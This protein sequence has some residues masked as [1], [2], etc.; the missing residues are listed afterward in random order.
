MNAGLGAAPVA[1]G[2][3]QGG[4]G[5]G[6]LGQVGRG[7]VRP[8]AV[9]QFHAGSAVADGITNAMFF[10][11][12]LL[13]AA[14]HR[15]EIY[16]QHIHPALRHR[17]QPMEAYPDAPGDLL[18]V[19]YSLG[20]ETDAWVGGLRTPRVLVYHNITPEAFFPPGSDLARLSVQGRQQL[21]RWALDGTF[22]A[23]IADSSYNAEEL[24]ALGFGLVAPIGLL[25]DLERIRAHAWTRSQVGGLAEVAPGTRLLLFVGRVARH[26]NQVALVAMMRRLVALSAQPVQLLMVGSVAW[27]EYGAEVEA[28]ITAAGLGGEVRLLGSCSDEDL[29]ALYRQADLYV[30]ASEHEGFG[31]PLVEAMA[32]DVPVLAHG[33]EGVAATLGGGGLVLQDCDPERMAAAAHLLLEDPALRRRLVLGQRE[34]LAR[35]ERPALVE[36]LVGHLRQAGFD[37]PIAMEPSSVEQVWSVSGPFDSSYSLALVN[38]ELARALGRG[39]RVALVSRDGPGAFPADP[40]FLEANPDLAAMSARGEAHAAVALR[41]QYP[42]HVADMRGAVRVLANH[43]WEES[44]FDPALVRE[45]NAS[46]DLVTVTSR[47]VAKV[48]RDNGVRVPIAVVG[49]GAD[50]V[51]P[52]AP[53]PDGGPFTFLHMSSCFPRKGV[54]VLLEAWGRAF[55]AA[56]GVALVIKGFPNPHNDVASQL[57]AFRARVPGHAAITLIDAELDEAAVAGLL[58]GADAVVC[59]SRGEGFGLPLAEAMA[60]GTPVVTTAHGGPVDFCTAETA[61]LVDYEFAYARTHLGLFDSVWAEPDVGSLVQ[62]L[63][64]VRTRPAERAARAAR[65][66]AAMLAHW[67]WDGVAAR[68]RAAVAAVREGSDAAGMRRPVIGLVSTWNVRCGIAAYAEAMLGAVERT[69]LH[70]FANEAGGLLGPDAPQVRRCWRQDGA[71]TLDGLFDAIVA[72]GVDAVVVQFNFGFFEKRAFV[73]LLGRLRERGMAV[74]VVMHATVGVERAD[75]VFTL[76]DVAEALR[77]VTRVLVHSVH[78]LNRLKVAG[79]VDNVALFPMGV[80]PSCPVERGALRRAL[81]WEGRRVLCSFGYLLPHKGLRELIG[82]V[83]LVRRRVPEVQLVMLNALYPAAESEAERAACEA[84][85]AR[86][87]LEAHVTMGTG[88]LAEARAMALLSASDLVVFPYQ[89]TQESASAAVRMGLASL[90]PVAVT[91]LP[92]FADVKEVCHALPGVSPEAMAEGI[93][94]ALAEPGRFAERQRNWAAAHGWAGLSTRLVGLVEGQFSDPF[95]RG[96]GWPPAGAGESGR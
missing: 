61:W 89:Y 55:T 20:S 64:D 96:S 14:G 2:R 3:G 16:C 23:A 35:F 37:V 77:G 43:A 85:V 95:A 94:A 76:A 33:A 7:L 69:R 87:G 27:G 34:Q 57:E 88:F 9:H 70:V 86:L 1:S 63:R 26:K 28:A 19:H 31:M 6:G 18:L 56:D 72:A 79:L 4:R 93:V 53:A 62:A 80:P 71:D 38:R 25:V 8:L 5:Q 82:A 68:T 11:Q 75:L 78:D 41:N 10:I 32:F 90:A 91:P 47:Y 46:L 12:R 29:F 45:F 58:D 54:D 49:N 65:G 74:Y 24:T 22:T 30:S 60:R 48:L 66:Q 15:S 40:A 83:D 44:G 13:Q 39:E 81:G 92:I 59:P 36:A 50:H 42:P 21:A 52:A 67:T 51:R 73:R 84:E 17:I